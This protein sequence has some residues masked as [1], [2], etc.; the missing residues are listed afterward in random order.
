MYA[1]L[2]YFAAST[3]ERMGNY[4]MWIWLGALIVSFP[5]A[6]WIF[7]RFDRAVMKRLEADR[8]LEEEA[9]GFPD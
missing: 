2:G 4:S 6:G 8:K 7:K 9:T 3:V 1:L 5:V